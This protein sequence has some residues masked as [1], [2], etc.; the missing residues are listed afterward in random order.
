MA[1]QGLRNPRQ[2]DGLPPWQNERM[3]AQARLAREARLAAR[4]GAAGLRE[5]VEPYKR[6]FR[7]PKPRDPLTEDFP[8]PVKIKR[9]TAEQRADMGDSTAIDTLLDQAIAE[10]PAVEP[11]PDYSAARKAGWKAYEPRDPYSPF[12]NQQMNPILMR[13]DV[14][15]VP[16]FT[17]RATLK[18]DTGMDYGRAYNQGFE[19]P[20]EVRQRKAQ[21]LVRQREGL[22]RHY[23]T[24]NALAG[25]A[26]TAPVAEARNQQALNFARQHGL[27]AGITPEESAA[28]A[29]LEG[30][31]Q[32]AQITANARLGAADIAAQSAKD[33]LDEDRRKTNYD[34]NVKAA[35]DFAAYDEKDPESVQ[36]WA[37]FTRTY[38]PVF[39]V[40]NSPADTH[41]LMKTMDTLS[42]EMDTY[43]IDLSFLGDRP[44]LDN[45]SDVARMWD[46]LQDV[47]KDNTHFKFN[48]I[49]YDIRKM[50]GS[51]RILSLIDDLKKS[52]SLRSAMD[53]LLGK[54][55]NGG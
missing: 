26:R 4:E 53:G 50:D 29:K 48:N 49:D 27:R 37:R 34:R 42:E 3:Q 30:D 41:N 25:Y 8:S 38:G 55:S 6:Y 7:P 35:K 51:S 1:D 52:T 9:P 36:R 19:L 10:E 24:L 20:D 13:T 2:R 39:E 21:E 40:L 31:F 28:R 23:D 14:G 11:F 43:G 18:K 5:A 46:A 15:G 16:E 44:P 12:R 47:T 32:K 17:D 45:I 33:R 54:T 22:R